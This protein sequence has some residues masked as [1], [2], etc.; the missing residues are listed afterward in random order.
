MSH[1]S[2]QKKANGMNGVQHP[3]SPVAATNGCVPVNLSVV[4][5][6]ILRELLQGPVSEVQLGSTLV[7][8]DVG[9]LMI[10]GVSNRINKGFDINISTND[11]QL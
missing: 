2:K 5:R 4:I 10:T 7:E 6:Q 3:D 8:L 1:I 9:L 11:L